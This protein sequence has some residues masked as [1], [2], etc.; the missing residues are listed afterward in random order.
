MVSTAYAPF[1][2]SHF[3]SVNVKGGLPLKAIQV[4]LIC[5]DDFSSWSSRLV[6]APWILSLSFHHSTVKHPRTVH[7][8]NNQINS[9]AAFIGHPY[10][11]NHW[12]LH[13][14]PRQ[15]PTQKQLHRN[16]WSSLLTAETSLSQRRPYSFA[17]LRRP[18]SFKTL[19]SDYTS[20]CCNQNNGGS[21][22]NSII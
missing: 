2:C 10:S 14:H 1:P 12:L 18:Y 5:S 20:F 15:R 19:T 17:S 4:L 22:T 7:W 8:T 11:F 9:I 21:S 13:I 6:F 16:D 3:D